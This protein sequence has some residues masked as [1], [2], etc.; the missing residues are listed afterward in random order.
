MEKFRWS[1]SG[2][3]R[4]AAGISLVVLKTAFLLSATLVST[5]QDSAF[6]VGKV[7]FG[8]MWRIPNPTAGVNMETLLLLPRGSGPF[9]LAVVN[10]GSSERPDIRAE[11]E[12]PKFE[13]ASSWFLKRGF[14][15]AMPQRPGYG[16]TGGPY[17]ESA[18]DCD[19]PFYEEA[20]Y[21]IGESIEYVIRY[22]QHQSFVKNTPAVVV[23]HSAGGWGALAA[24]THHSVNIG[25]VVNFSGG[26][27]GRSYGLANRNCAP[28]RLVS[29]A[30]DYGR[31]TRIPTLWLYAEND[32]FFGPQLSKRMADAY[33][34][35]GGRVEYHLFP[36]ISNE[37]HFLIYSSE[38]VR[39][40][41][42]LADKF[43]AS[44]RG[45][46]P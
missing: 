20:G 30:A 11:Y 32:T 37:G 43:I 13:V 35:A 18:G 6:S 16:N 19:S 1:A 33:R 8:Q 15:V 42:G 40:W 23:G 21:A 38:S 4:A 9:P 14:A 25:A 10:H 12:I 3:N 28:D 45:A 26:L 27:G 39:L 46:G 44:I 29:A 7:P 41:S 24:A 5:A 36:S 34:S 2:V 31:T 17:L 22:F